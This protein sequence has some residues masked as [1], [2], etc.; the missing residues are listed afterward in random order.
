MHAVSYSLLLLNTDLHVVDTDRR[1]TKNQ[2][3]RNTLSAISMQSEDGDAEP[4]TAPALL[5]RTATRDDS[6]K[7]DNVFGGNGEASASRKS[8]DRA[9]SRNG[10]VVSWN[11]STSSLANGSPRLVRESPHRPQLV[12]ASRSES[13][14]TVNSASSH[15]SEAALE[16]TLKVRMVRL[17]C[18]AFPD[19][20]NCFAG[21]VHRHQEPADLSAAQLAAQPARESL[22]VVSLAHAQLVTLRYLERRQSLSQSTQRH[23]DH[24][25]I[26]DRLQALE[27]AGLW[28]LS[29]FVKCRAGSL[30]ESDTER[31]YFPQRCE[32]WYIGVVNAELTIA[33]TP[34]RTTSA[35]PMALP[36]ITSP[37]SG[38]PTA[39]RTPSSASS[40]RTT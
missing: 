30:V 1:M 20:L 22:A 29:H 21:D 9:A 7:G 4:G 11:A 27:R 13:S 26:V 28:Q 15:R 8:L 16:S 10:S 19:T 23:L 36:T 3:V 38:L 25:R 32:L 18:F 12:N 40:K 6:E 31:C 14:A 5:F 33:L 34:C 17:G 2:F 39:S 37:P 24:E 35:R